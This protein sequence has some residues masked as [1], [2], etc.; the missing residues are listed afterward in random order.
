MNDYVVP[1]ADLVAHVRD[2]DKLAVPSDFSGFYSGVAME[3]TRELVRRGVRDLHL[4]VL[5]TAGLQADLLIGAGCIGTLEASSIFMGE[6]GVPPRFKHAFA[7]GAIRTIEATCPAIHAGFQAGE[8]GIPFMP[9]RGIIGS[10]VVKLR[11]DWKVVPNPMADGGDPILLVPAIRPD[12]T[13][14]HAPM[15]D[16]FGNV[17]YGRRRELAVMA[18]AAHGTLATVEKL[19]DGNLMDD[20]ALSC[21]TLPNV[22]TTAVSVVPRGAWPYGHGDDYAEDSQEIRRYMAAA[23]TDEGFA[24]YIREGVFA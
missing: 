1:L 4:V 18:R 13:L 23:E 24:A 10:D 7:T 17:W 20:A 19:Y 21:A 8:K 11:P 22:Y 12:W 14:F 2:G 5:P 15:A 6:Y 3:A 16:R 9:I